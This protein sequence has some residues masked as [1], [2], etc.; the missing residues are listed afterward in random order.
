MG[1]GSRAA[2]W[3]HTAFCVPRKTEANRIGMIGF[4][5][6][7]RVANRK[8]AE[9]EGL[10]NVAPN[11]LVARRKPGSAFPFAVSDELAFKFG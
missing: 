8:E 5:S 2:R 6:V 11:R 9:P 7:Q 4:L 10:V 1:A 3:K